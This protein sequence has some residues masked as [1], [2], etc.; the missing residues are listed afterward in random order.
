M[1]NVEFASRQTAG[2]DVKTVGCMFDHISPTYDTLNHI[3]SLGLDFFWRKKLAD[4]V[5][6][7]NALRI[8]DL[9]TGTGDVLISLLHR[10][11]NITEA[12]GLDI[13]ENMLALCR[14][15]I[16]RHK[17]SDRVNLVRSDAT[18][19]PFADETFDI[20]TMSFGI[21][22]TP[23]VLKTL[24]EIHRLLQPGGKVLILEFSMPT[25]QI[26]K[27]SYLLYLRSFVPFLGRLLSG[28]THAYKYLTKSIESFVSSKDFLSFMLK[29]GFS[30][31]QATPL[32]FGVVCL[33]Q[34]FKPAC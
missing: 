34:G 16:A 3:L 10:N 2:L 30:D 12:V 19:N 32:S 24:K 28:D 15:K 6:K 13:S 1:T 22:N 23:D 21:R 9:A 25:N 11:S 29:A 14:N 8:L 4:C 31:V 20:I 27:M 5:D 7:E 33:Y 17:F 18:I 26:F